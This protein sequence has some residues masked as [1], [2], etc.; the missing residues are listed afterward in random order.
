MSSFTGPENTPWPLRRA[1]DALA[2]AARAAGRPGLVWIAGLS[3]PAVGAGLGFGLVEGST[4]GAYLRLYPS[5]GNDLVGLL[6]SL[7]IVL[8]PLIMRLRVGLARIAPPDVWQRL[9]ETFG[10]AR[11]KHAWRA[12]AGL[13]WS[14]LGLS[15]LMWLMLLVAIAAVGAPVWALVRAGRGALGAPGEVLFSLGLALPAVALLS[16]YSLT[17]SVLHQLALQSLAHNRRGVNSALL[18]AWRI[19]REDPWAT[20]RTLAL[21]V[22]LNLTVFALAVLATAALGLLNLEPLAVL[23]VQLPLIGFLG[24]TR[25]GYWARAYRGLGGLS[26]DDAVPGLDAPRSSVAH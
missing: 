10:R 16:A 19:A 24:V 9:H 5:G 1:V 17:L 23:A 3:Y 18:H 6:F 13:T 15:I 2:R 8:L 22:V 20:G 11:L 25:A 21:D 14:T 4:S 26:P 12:G 7:G